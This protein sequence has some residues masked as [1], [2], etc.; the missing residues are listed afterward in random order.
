MSGIIINLSGKIRL[1]YLPL[2]FP[3]PGLFLGCSTLF[4]YLG[5][6]MTPAL[7]HAWV[8]GEKWQKGPFF[9]NMFANQ[10]WFPRPIHGWHERYD[11][12]CPILGGD[13]PALQD[14]SPKHQ[15]KKHPHL[16]RGFCRPAIVNAITDLEKRWKGKL[17]VTK[18]NGYNYNMAT[19]HVAF[20]ES[21]R[22]NKT[23]LKICVLWLIYNTYTLT[24]HAADWYE[25]LWPIDTWATNLQISKQEDA[26]HKLDQIG[27][28]N[29]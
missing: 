25:S 18:K 28:S 12:R 4:Q 13:H 17:F 8:L 29:G 11:A 27:G 14:G 26:L 24:K 20:V 5:H 15:K 21:G 1:S 6:Y 22:V 16:D 10:V 2:T 7:T 23:W 19:C 9:R 3:F